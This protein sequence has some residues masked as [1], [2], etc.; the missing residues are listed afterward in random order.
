LF[1]VTG[2]SLGGGRWTSLRWVECSS[3]KFKWRSRTSA[4]AVEA[5]HAKRD[6]KE[7]KT[8]KALEKKNARRSR[9]KK[10]S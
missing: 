9:T 7:M 10:D 6:E 5:Y 4:N 2:S 8:R 1:V 3:C